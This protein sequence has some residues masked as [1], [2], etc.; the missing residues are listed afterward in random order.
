MKTLG[1]RSLSSVIKIIIDA[2]WYIQLFLL[3]LATVFLT[4]QTHLTL[5]LKPFL[6]V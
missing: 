4:Y 5:D 6:L 3:G 2:G 1:N